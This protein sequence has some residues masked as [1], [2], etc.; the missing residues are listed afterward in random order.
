[1]DQREPVFFEKC[2][3]TSLDLMDIKPDEKKIIE[4]YASGLRTYFITEIVKQSNLLSVQLLDMNLEKFCLYF[5][6]SNS[7]GLNLSF[8]DIITAK[9]YVDYKLQDSI[10]KAKKNIPFLMIN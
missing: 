10:T 7:Q 9:V 1:M 8:I 4:G 6:R 5:E 2:C 3:S